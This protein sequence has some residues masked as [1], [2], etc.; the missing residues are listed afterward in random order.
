MNKAEIL[1]RLQEIDKLD[2]NAELRDEIRSLSDVFREY[3]EQEFHEAKLSKLEGDDKN[4]K[5][6]EEIQKSIELNKEFKAL[7][8]KFKEKD[9]VWKE[10][11]DEIINEILEKKKELLK[12]LEFINQTDKAISI[13]DKYDLFNSIREEWNKLGSLK[14]EA[15]RDLK[16][17]FNAEVQKFYHE[18][19]IDKEFRDMHFKKNKEQREEIIEKVRQ[20]DSEAEIWKTDAFLKMYRKEWEDSGMVR[21]EDFENLKNEFWES[22]RK[23]ADKI[24]DFFRKKDEEQEVIVKQKELLIERI[25]EL[26]KIKSTLI[27]EWNEQSDK[28]S[29][30]IKEWRKTGFV[31]RK[32]NKEIWDTFNNELDV[33]FNGKRTFFNELREKRKEIKDRKV[34]IIDRI[35]E[36]AKEPGDWNQSTDEVKKLQQDWKQSGRLRSNEEDKLWAKLREVSDSFFEKKKQHFESMQEV[37]SE[38]KEEKRQLLTEFEKVE[39][40]D[41][42]EEALDLLSQWQ[43]K[44]LKAGSANFISEKK[45]SQQFNDIVRKHQSKLDIHDD[46]KDMFSFRQKLK[47]FLKSENGKD[48]IE[49]EKR[50]VKN[51]LREAEDELVK[52]EDSM[53]LFTF[54]GKN[55]SSPLLVEAEKKLENAKKR[56]DLFKEKSIVLKTTKI[57]EEEESVKESEEN[58]EKDKES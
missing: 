52:L 37:K 1:E 42:K 45:L 24:E 3:M 16:N 28:V 43:D 40:P 11:K 27:K 10:K 32:K 36:L 12:R 39:M 20:L 14:K 15:Y 4:Q 8:E 26:N 41:D 33:F 22:Y 30:V 34:A 5:T 13:K 57:V 53:A 23:I 58:E 18:I 19:E 29:E 55:N 6:P 47:R 7:A 54:S 35:A 44:W 56:R 31:S 9:K 2:Y 21:K 25:R 38:I 49:R 46:E 17:Q 51:K 50:F 48:L